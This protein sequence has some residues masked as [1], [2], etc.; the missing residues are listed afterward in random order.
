MFPLN[1]INN[2][3]EL[4]QS[5]RGRVN[6]VIQPL[7]LTVVGNIYFSVPDETARKQLRSQASENAHC[8]LIVCDW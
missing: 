1:L 5:A 4:Q 2:S 8:I 6:D 7:I 3:F